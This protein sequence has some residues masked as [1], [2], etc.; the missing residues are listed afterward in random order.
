MIKLRGLHK[1]FNR[2]KP[3]EIHVINDVNLELPERGM[4]AIYGKSGCGKTTLLNVIGGLDRFDGGV[5]TLDGQS[6]REHTDE[7]RNRYIGYIFQNYNLSKSESC[8]DNVAA[9]LR[10]CG[11]TDGREIE[12]RVM[13]ALRNVG[14]EKYAHRP[15][16][17]LSGGQQQRIA[18][19]RAIVKNPRVILAD[20]PTG[21][22]DEAN[23]VMI[24]DLL[25]AIAKDHLVLLVTHEADLVAH[26]CDLAIRLQDGRVVNVRRN[27]NAGGLA[28]RDKNDIYLGELGKAEFKSGLVGIEYYGDVPDHPVQLKVVNH[29]GKLYVRIETP[30]VKLV[31]DYSEIK[32]REGVYEA[33]P[34]KNTVSAD[35]DMSALPPVEGTG[36]GRLFTFRSS[37][38][39]GYNANFQKGKK[40]K[41]ALRGCM[42]LFAAVL[43]LMSAVFGTALGTVVQAK[44]TYNHNIFYVY[45]PEDGEI[46]QKLNEAVGAA[47][48]GIDFVRM[49]PSYP[50]SE[51]Y[52]RFKV[53][54][55][56]TFR[57]SSYDVGT[58]AAYLPLSLVAGLSPVTGKKEGLSNE[59]MVITTKVADALLE[60]SSVGYISEYEDL[61][62][63]VCIG[64]SVNNAHP[65]IAGVVRSE[66]RAVYLTDFTLAEYVNS[67]TDLYIDPA[68]SY[69]LTVN[70]GVAVFVALNDGVAAPKAGDTV[71]IG[72]REIKVTAVLVNYASYRSFLQG[73]GIEKANMSNYF[74]A[75]LLQQ[76]PALETDE[77]A[78]QTAVAEAQVYRYYEYYDYYYAELSEYLEGYAMFHTDDIGP[79]LALEKGI[80][81]APYLFLENYEYALA[82]VYKAEH[83]AYPTQTE[84]KQQY[85]GVS[86]T[87]RAR[88]QAYC[89][90]Y[91]AEF[92][93]AGIQ[94]CPFTRYQSYYLHEIDYI[95]L[96]R[97]TGETHASAQPA[98]KASSTVHTGYNPDLGSA[99]IQDVDGFDAYTLIHSND[100]KATERWLKQEFAGY[101][102]G[103]E[104]LW[105]V[106]PDAMFDNLIANDMPEVIVGLV[107]LVLILAILSLCMYFIMRSSL[108]SRI[109]EIGIYRAIGVSKGNLIFKFLVEALVLTTLTVFIGYAISSGF[110]FAC[111]GISSFVEEIFYYPWWM[112][113]GVL[114]LLYALCV[115][116]GVWPIL[117]LLRKTP[118]EILA[119]Y[120]I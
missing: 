27:E 4:V 42:A 111:Y 105:V 96:S 70:E 35:V 64:L 40:G 63:M 93:S 48:T 2:G 33:D 55:F 17:T 23:T 29:G 75:L 20:E 109:K 85:K 34:A 5:I 8:F 57:D 108:M 7:I 47:G 62:G 28:A 118:S 99:A 67:R 120:D 61:L 56:E 115:F 94:P 117:S 60:A 45:T 88:Y 13:A 80:D 12:T 77:S 18:I 65:R 84:L 73:N 89:K 97:Q 9:A 43:V 68:A 1:F 21:N 74:K 25:K 76:N 69:D 82:R 110:L 79:W 26:Y 53:G 3:N 116:C 112:A 104:R 30:G 11:M 91:E 59:E 107:A 51:T 90:T 72:G 14:M 50:F 32:L 41:K 98:Y 119:K 78:L 39:S 19:A 103:T 81:E 114:V 37:V 102:T 66:E 24:M 38:K 92:V 86:T 36:H 22:L 101:D 16:D 100:P 87:G 71:K 15:P 113:G 49:Y 6:I 83:G 54:Y 31:D 52:V 44:D 58:E 106:T 10:L 46:S 95:A